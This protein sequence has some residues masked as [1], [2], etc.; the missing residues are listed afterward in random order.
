MQ[1][2]LSSKLYAR[3]REDAETSVAQCSAGVRA[4]WE[5][6]QTEEAAR[7]LSTFPYKPEFRMSND[8]FK[9][10]LRAHVGLTLADT[11]PSLFCSAG[12]GTVT[13]CRICGA[14]NITDMDRHALNCQPV[15]KRVQSTRHNDIRDLLATYLR[16]HAVTRVETSLA[17]Y[18]VQESTTKQINHRADI[19]LHTGGD[20]MTH[21]IDITVVAGSTLE[22]A[23]AKKRKH[24][25][26]HYGLGI[27]NSGTSVIPFAVD[28]LGRWG[29]PAQ[30]AAKDWAAHSS[31]MLPVHAD[32]AYS[33]ALDHF[34][35]GV[36][37]ILARHLGK[38]LRRFCDTFAATVGI[39]PLPP[40]PPEYDTDA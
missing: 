9:L 1:F 31:H 27:K 37:C 29:K 26:R 14:S 15:L 7:W 28:P 21:L 38:L 17:P 34:H 18:F 8:E 3:M 35:A 2:T 5:S 20:A 36:S 6:T 32:P 12:G 39:A 13:A 19:T 4:L 30:L 16:K 11:H 22:V 40:A 33:E 23:E 25:G 10:A 24:Y